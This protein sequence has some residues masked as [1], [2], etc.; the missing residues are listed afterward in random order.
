VCTIEVKL[1]PSPKVTAESTHTLL[2]AA[3]FHDLA[4]TVAAMNFFDD[5]FIERLFR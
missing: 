2:S 5:G 3:S 1:L 4:V